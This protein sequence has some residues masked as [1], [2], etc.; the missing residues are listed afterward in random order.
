MT[1]V[2]LHFWGVANRHIPSALARM[3]TS[4]LDLRG[5]EHL[6]FAKLLG[7]AKPTTF[8]PT[9]TDFNHW[10]LLTVCGLPAKCAP[11][12]FPIHCWT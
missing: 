9:A 10:G 11:T 1:Y 4:R 5:I 8:T 2:R 7:T 6:S 12:R 3:G